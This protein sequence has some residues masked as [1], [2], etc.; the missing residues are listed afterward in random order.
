MGRAWISTFRVGIPVMAMTAVLLS[1][2]DKRPV[3]GSGAAP[4]SNASTAS[5]ASPASSTSAPTPIN[6]VGT[7]WRLDDLGGAGVIDNSQAT[8]TF[9]EGGRVAGNGSCNRFT[10]AAT[11]TGQTVKMGP[12]ASTRMA[13][14]SEAV[15]NQELKYLKALEGAMHYEWKEPY[16]LIYC[17][18][19]E[20]P[21]RFTK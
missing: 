9:L 14:P 21:L 3:A 19:L 11:I 6:L 1:C 4:S 10:G 7:E 8:L 18:G 13:C 2:S 16:L 12:M 17:D 5:S 20:K 15:S